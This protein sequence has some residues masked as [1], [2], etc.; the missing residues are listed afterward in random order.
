MCV[1]VCMF[2]WIFYSAPRTFRLLLCS[3]G[4]RLIFLWVKIAPLAE[5][6]IV[7]VCWRLCCQNDGLY[8]KQEER[9]FRKITTRL[10]GNSGFK[11]W[12]CLHD[13]WAYS[14]TWVFISFRFVYMYVN[15]LSLLGIP[16]RP[17]S[18]LLHVNPVYCKPEQPNKWI[19]TCSHETSFTWDVLS[20]VWFTVL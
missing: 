1:C 6:T 4:S 19:N 9:T 16:K 3:S 10:S 2:I 11:C 12:N 20:F 15:I 7:S 18:K 17:I 13:G 14:W 8:W 5:D